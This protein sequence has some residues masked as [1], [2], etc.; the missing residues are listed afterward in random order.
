M[1]LQ[2]TQKG[3]AK[4]IDQTYYQKSSPW[5]RTR[6]SLVFLCCLAAVLYIVFAMGTG[7]AQ[8][9]HNPGNLMPAHASFQN[10]CEK[11][12]QGTGSSFSLVV[13]DQACLKCHDAAIH[14]QNQK[15]QV[16]LVNNVATRA[17]SCVDCHVEH[18]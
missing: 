10:N 3:L 11:C 1:A 8:S 14:N 9:I 15:N 13:T 17:A 7:R 6:K 16:V 4:R 12:H 2:R 5:R 18:R